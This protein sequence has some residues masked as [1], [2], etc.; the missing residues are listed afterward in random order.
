MTR[1]YPYSHA[2]T[3]LKEQQVW[4]VLKACRQSAQQIA[5]DQWKALFITGSMKK[6]GP[7]CPPD[8]I[9]SKRYRQTCQRQV[10]GVLKSWLSNRKNVFRMLVT[11]SSLWKDQTE[12]GVH[13]RVQLLYINKYGLWFRDRV[14]M[15]TEVIPPKVMRLAR[16]LFRRLMNIHN[17]PSFRYVGMALDAK[18]AKV[19]KP[20]KAQPCRIPVLA[21]S[22][23]LES[24][25]A[26]PHPVAREPIRSGG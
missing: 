12:A 23:Y 6:D 14:T 8:H 26:H 7:I 11:H 15:R 9:I 25:Q 24:A 20:D 10:V 21:D 16:N 22:G 4:E 17:K 3:A 2:A 13:L 18:A 1:T 19:E 5:N